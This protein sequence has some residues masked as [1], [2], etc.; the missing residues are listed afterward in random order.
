MRQIDPQALLDILRADRLRFC[1]M[2]WELN[3][4]GNE[5][6]ASEDHSCF[7]LVHQYWYGPHATFTG[8]DPAFL[9]QVLRRY[10][11]LGLCVDLPPGAQLQ[12]ER[13]RGLKAYSLPFEFF[14]YDGDIPAAP[15]DLHIRLLDES[16][17]DL[18]RPLVRDEI[19][20]KTPG[21]QAFAWF[22]GEQIAGYLHCS[23]CYEDIWDVGYVFT[24]PEHQGRGIGAAL[25]YAYRKTIR[26]QG[27]TPYVSGVT[28][29]ASAAAA[30]KAGFLP[31]SIRYAYKYKRPKIGF[32]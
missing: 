10:P 29:P 15:I 17:F 16:E 31:C 6:F 7:A 4:G 27:E 13:M 8:Y 21:M 23:P 24:L 18:L 30:R 26:E 20:L 5:A 9:R 25:Y 3:Q 2:L 19:E 32:V 28:N 1:G 22:E 12:I 14:A 11:K